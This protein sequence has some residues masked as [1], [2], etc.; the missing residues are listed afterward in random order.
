MPYHLCKRGERVDPLA[1]ESSN[2][3]SENEPLIFACPPLQICCKNVENSSPVAS[4][5]KEE[6]C[7]NGLFN[8]PDKCGLRNPNGLSEAVDSSHTSY[9]K[10]A[11]FPWV[12]AVLVRQEI[13]GEILK[14]YQSSGSLIHPKVVMTTVRS[15][16]RVD[17]KKLVAWAGKWDL[18]SDREMCEHEEQKVQKVIRHEN[19][20]RDNLHSDIA[21][22]IMETE[23]LTTPFVNTVCLPPKN[24]NFSNQSCLESGWGK[25]RFESLETVLTKHELSIISHDDCQKTIRETRSEDFKLSGDFICAGE[26]KKFSFVTLRK[27]FILQTGGEETKICTG[28]GGA[29]LVCEVQSNAQHYH[30]VGIAVGS[31]DCRSE[32]VPK[33]FVDVAKYR[34]WIAEKFLDLSLDSCN[35]TF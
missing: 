32:N 21:L 7:M 35:Y 29:P 19:F 1:Y 22:L 18:Q 3:S 27:L 12:V 24:T 23:F 2:G 11:E 28:D 8:A 25:N 9:A 5:Y 16:A 10:Y 33:F 26:L 4:E 15:I 31:S 13:K 6:M 30:Q 17:A 34:D 14:V 20:T